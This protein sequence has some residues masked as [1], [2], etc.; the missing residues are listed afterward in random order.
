MKWALRGPRGRAIMGP[1][2]LG[3]MG[4]LGLGFGLTLAAGPLRDSL[5]GLA[6][7]PPSPSLFGA[8]LAPLPS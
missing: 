2:G 6:A 4:A 1:K 7:A 5:K 3:A 8:R